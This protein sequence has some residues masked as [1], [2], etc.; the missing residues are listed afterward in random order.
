MEGSCSTDTEIFMWGKKNKEI[1]VVVPQYEY[2]LKITHLK[3]IVC[4]CSL[5][6]SSLILPFFFVRHQKFFRICF[7]PYTAFLLVFFPFKPVLISTNHCRSQTKQHHRSTMPISREK[8]ENGKKNAL[9]LRSEVEEKVPLLSRCFSNQSFLS[10]H[11]D[12]SPTTSS[13]SHFLISKCLLKI[14]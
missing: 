10:F 7:P 1:I 8:R 11:L 12:F 3:P 2:R 13:S 5:L 4:F 6:I 9:R 14:K